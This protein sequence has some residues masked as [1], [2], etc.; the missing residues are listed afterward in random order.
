MFFRTIYAL[1]VS[2]IDIIRSF[3]FAKECVLLFASL[4]QANFLQ[5]LPVLIVATPSP[6]PFSPRP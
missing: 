1:N 4:S 2:L 5:V 6:P 3:I